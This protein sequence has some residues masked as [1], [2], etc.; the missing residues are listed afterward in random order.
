MCQNGSVIQK[1]M[2]I[3]VLRIFLAGLLAFI[4]V[5]TVPRGLSLAASSDTDVPIENV[6]SDFPVLAASAIIPISDQPFYP[7]LLESYRRWATAPLSSVVGDSPRDTLLNFYAVMTHVANDTDSIRDTYR[8][9]SGL[10]WGSTAR[11]GI[12][13]AEALFAL[14]THAL[15]SSSFP[16]SIRDDMSVEAA[17][18]LKE[19]LDYVFTHSQFP[20]NIPDQIGLKALNAQRTNSLDSWTLPHTLIILE[21]TVSGSREV[22]GFLFSTSTVSNIKRMYDLIR[23]LPKVDQPFATPELYSRYI[24]SPGY[25]V[26]PLWYLR[27]TPSTRN[28][29]ETSFF[30]QT[31][32]QLL[33]TLFVLLIY[34]A[35]A[36][37]L[38]RRFLHTFGYSR[39]REVLPVSFFL[40]R[41][42]FNQSWY[43]VIIIL[44]LLPLGLVSSLVIDNYINFT[45]VPLLYIKYIFS[46]CFYISLSTLVFLL[47]D[48]LGCTVSA[49]LVQWRGG[50]SELQLQRVSNLI[51]PIFRVFGASASMIAIYKLLVVL[52]LPSTTVLAFSAVPGLAI[53]L[54]ASKLLGNLFGGLSIQTDRPVRVGE[55]CQIGQTLGFVTKIGMRSLVLQTLD[56]RVTIPNSIVDEQ[57]IVNFSRRDSNSDERPAQSLVVRIAVTR[58]FNSDQVADLLFFAR[59]AL[60]D[61]KGVQEPLVSIEEEQSEGCT[62]LCYALVAV[63]SWNDY[64]L[65]RERMLL[66]LEQVVEQ[67]HLSQRAIGVSYDTSSDQLERIPDLIRDLV[68]SDPLL[69]LKSCRLMTIAAFSYEF[70]F[71]FHAHHGSLSAI[72][73]SIDRLNHDLLIA[74]ANQGIEIPY[75]TAVEIRKPA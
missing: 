60:I 37:F 40:A 8:N 30:E 55:F 72:K 46:F 61:I 51:V 39:P 2:S 73:D 75:P 41:F 53:G 64:I 5:L 29:L 45:G 32:L 50:S 59:L 3:K 68:E 26:P 47:F 19:V 12:Q 58:Q 28:L 52:G 44:P 11:I 56:S 16:E 33:A 49:R 38:L 24:S 13:K 54:G 34:I 9:H 69:K 42:S 57:T 14:A 20:I 43:R 27:L 25:I 63:H 18:E 4:L 21:N 62:I 6:I 7:L 23:D 35:S 17:L 74:F 48:A 22:P 70:N 71:R 31:I 15:D 67:V 36:S 10:F 1:L 65:V 66:R